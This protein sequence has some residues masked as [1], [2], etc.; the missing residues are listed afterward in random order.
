M[1]QRPLMPLHFVARVRPKSGFCAG[2]RMKRKR[3]VPVNIAN[4]PIGHLVRDVGMLEVL[5]PMPHHVEP[6]Q[7]AIESL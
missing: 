4:L 1:A 5:N 2:S 7:G 3:L 6:M